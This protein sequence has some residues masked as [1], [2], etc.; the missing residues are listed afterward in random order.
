MILILDTMVIIFD[1]VTG[2]RY[3]KRP[4]AEDDELEIDRFELMIVRAGENAGLSIESQLENLTDKI[5]ERTDE[6][7]KTNIVRLLCEWL[8]VC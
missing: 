1:T 4:R 6:S 7:D 8:V 3:K 2:G 5:I